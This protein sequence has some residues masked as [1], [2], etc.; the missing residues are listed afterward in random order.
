M[1]LTEQGKTKTT[2][3]P[4]PAVF[5]V[6][7]SI[8][9]II[10]RHV[11]E[12]AAGKSIAFKMA[13]VNRLQVF[14]LR[15]IREPNRADEPIAQVRSGEW[16]RLRTEPESG[17]ARMFAPKITSIV[18]ARSG[19]TRL[20]VGPLPSPVDGAGMLKTGTIRYLDN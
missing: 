17:V 14:A 8:G 6:G 13:A 5:A 4:R 1:E 12:L 11:A 18:D 20:V 3:S 2:R 10:E 7:P 16:L 15:V 9:R 19:R